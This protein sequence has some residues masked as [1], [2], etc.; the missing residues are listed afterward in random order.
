MKAVRQVCEDSLRIATS[1]NTPKTTVA[2]AKAKNS[3]II[4][5][6]LSA[7]RAVNYTCSPGP[8]RFTSREG[9]AKRH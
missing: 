7:Q 3:F 4:L 5:L 9:Y 2:A 6:V 1:N 8:E